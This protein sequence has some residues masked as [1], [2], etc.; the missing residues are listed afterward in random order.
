MSRLPPPS[1]A[2]ALAT[3]AATEEA[4]AAPRRRVAASG[5]SAVQVHQPKDSSSSRTRARSSRTCSGRSRV[6]YKAACVRC[7]VRDA[8][9][10]HPYGEA[11]L[12]DERRLEDED[13]QYGGPRVHVHNPPLLT[14]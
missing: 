4:A 10:A 12:R 7:H 2:V 11:L 1:S 3:R 6:S 14:V 5:T 13:D 9:H 8:S